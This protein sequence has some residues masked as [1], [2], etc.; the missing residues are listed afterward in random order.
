MGAQFEFVIKDGVRMVDPLSLKM[1]FK[2]DDIETDKLLF[3][4]P[5]VR[6]RSS[7]SYLPENTLFE[8]FAFEFNNIHARDKAVFSTFLKKAASYKLAQKKLSEQI[9]RDEGYVQCITINPET[10]DY[11]LQYGCVAR[12]LEIASAKFLKFSNN[13]TALALKKHEK[14]LY[15]YFKNFNTIVPIHSESNFVND[16]VGSLDVE[17][18]GQIIGN[19]Q[20]TGQRQPNEVSIK[21]PFVKKTKSEVAQ[22]ILSD[23]LKALGLE[24]VPELKGLTA[25][26]MEEFAKDPE[27]SEANLGKLSSVYMGKLFANWHWAKRHLSDNTLYSLAKSEVGGSPIYKSDKILGHKFANKESPLDFKTYFNVKNILLVDDNKRTGNTSKA[28]HHLTRQL[29][30]MYPKQK[31]NYAWFFLYNVG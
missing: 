25:A 14:T 19:P 31:I 20:W 21:S 27:Y 10:N 12:M 29:D 26:D 6:M 24:D 28:I 15:N 7:N 13:I 18:K 8:Y 17:L 9:D 5:D 16:I 1:N 22:E 30:A 4:S 23:P 3:F 11:E 2:V